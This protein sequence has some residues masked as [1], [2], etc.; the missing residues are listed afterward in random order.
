MVNKSL[1]TPLFN[2]NSRTKEKERNRIINPLTQNMTIYN[3][4]IIHK[5]KAYR[6]FKSST[7]NIMKL[8][9]VNSNAYNGKAIKFTHFT[10]N[11]TQQKKSVGIR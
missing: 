4:T 11:Y 9:F 8:Q 6:Q 2:D 3:T 10:E 1:N 7:S 5:Q